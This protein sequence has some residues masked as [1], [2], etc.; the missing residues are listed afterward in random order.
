[1]SLIP[2]QVKGSVS[3]AFANIKWIPVRPNNRFFTYVPN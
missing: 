3:S 2:F 1:M